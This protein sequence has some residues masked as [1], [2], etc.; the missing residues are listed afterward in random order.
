M[1]RKKYETELEYAE[2]VRR[3]A[4]ERGLR[5]AKAL[6]E[7]GPLPAVENPERRE[8]CRLDLRLF[9]TTYFPHLFTHEFSPAHDKLI[10]DLQNGIL[11]GQSSVAVLP[12]GFGKT[13]V[14][15]C[16]VL[17]AVL[18]GHRSYV[19]LVSASATTAKKLLQ[20]IHHELLYNPHLAAPIEQDTPAEE[21]PVQG[22]FPEVCI[23]IR[24]LGRS[25]NRQKGQTVDGHPTQMNISVDRFIF[26]TVEGSPST[27]CVIESCGITAG[28]RGKNVTT[29]RGSLRPD[30]VILDDIQTD[31]SAK[32]PMRVDEQL[33]LLNGTLK[34]LAGVDQPLT[35]VAALTVIEADDLADRLIKSPSW[36]A[37]KFGVV[38]RLP[39][40]AAIEKWARLNQ[41][42][43]DAI[44]EGLND[45]EVTARVNE[46]FEAD[47]AALI[48]GCTPT[49]NAFK[50]P[51][52]VNAMQKIMR[53]Y[54]DDFNTFSREYMNDPAL[55]VTADNQQLTIEQLNEKITSYKR[56]ALPLEAEYLTVG[57][58]SQTLGIFYTVMAHG[59]DGSAW[60]I[61]YG[62]YPK[63]M[64]RTITQQ[65]DGLPLDQAIYAGYKDLL[66]ELMNR[67]YIRPDG[68]ELRI[69]RCVMD[70][71]HGPT[72]AKIQQ[73]IR[74]FNNPALSPLF[75]RARDPNE[76]IFGK[77]KPGELRGKGWSMPPVKR[78]KGPDGKYITMP[79]AVMVDVNAW[80]SAL[81]AGLQARLGTPGSISLFYDAAANHREYFLHLTS[82]RS[83]TLSG[84]YGSID[85]F[86]LLPNRANHWLDTTVYALAAG[87]MVQKL[88]GGPTMA[89]KVEAQ[90]TRK[91]I[92]LSD[93]QKQRGY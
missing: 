84:K 18:Y 68:L 8:Q 80:K 32:N 4:H 67:T 88:G 86:K 45:D 56:N 55:A 69:S 47:K 92:K 11:H 15:L 38:D 77:K 6:R 64:K 49:W 42:R 41:I 53:L 85:M 91:R 57:C 25:S 20:N 60:I 63:T 21:Y 93:I 26:P 70:C 43:A 66:T 23:P 73:F 82:E 13:T 28:I 2:S 1:P 27:G 61:D 44:A 48:D 12:R 90:F 7:I 10:L 83:S 78:V 40:D 14:A 5:V 87:S 81:R 72:S 50:D 58:D 34:G 62:K 31:K 65:Y 52:D 54:F 16:S 22:D 39:S 29:S 59:V 37:A 76:L 9:L 46:A 35:M 75:G 17:W 30:M 79:R 24:R 33:S 3:V 71:S 19:L 89:P 36:R 51:G 74:D